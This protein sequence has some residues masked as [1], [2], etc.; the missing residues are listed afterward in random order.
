MDRW[1]NSGALGSIQRLECSFKK[2][3]KQKKTLDKYKQ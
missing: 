1:N 2:K 3:T